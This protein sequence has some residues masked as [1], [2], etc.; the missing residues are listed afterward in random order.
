MAALSEELR[1][2]S[3]L[4]PHVAKVLSALPEG[5]HPMTQFSTAVLSLQ[6]RRNLTLMIYYPWRVV[7]NSIP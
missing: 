3:A 1:S 6:A 7:S 4:P 2:R 5:T